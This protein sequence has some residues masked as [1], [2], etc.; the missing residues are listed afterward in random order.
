M[1]IDNSMAV[2]RGW[3]W[4]RVNIWWQNTLLWLWAHNA[5]YRECVIEMYA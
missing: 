2:T 1:D 4:K 5:I 3:G